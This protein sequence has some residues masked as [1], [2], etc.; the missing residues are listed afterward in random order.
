MQTLEEWRIGDRITRL[1]YFLLAAVGASAQCLD[2]DAIL[3]PV[4][5]QPDAGEIIAL[6]TWQAPS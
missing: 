1:G 3:P 5:E 4:A 2:Y 6:E